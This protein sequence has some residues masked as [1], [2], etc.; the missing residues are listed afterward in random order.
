MNQPLGDPLDLP[1]DQASDVHDNSPAETTD[2]PV[3]EGPPPVCGDVE[4][5]TILVVGTDFRGTNYLYGLA[6]VIRIV[7]I[8]FTIPQVN[9]V[10]LPRAIL[11]EDP[12]QILK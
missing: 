7:H 6:D 5:M 4:E 9:I 8:D 11:I 2:E 3:D 12:G 10:A 1:T